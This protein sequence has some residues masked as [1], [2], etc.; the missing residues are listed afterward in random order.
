M[1]YEGSVTQGSPVLQT[2]MLLNSQQGN[3]IHTWIVTSEDGVEWSF[4]SWWSYLQRPFQDQMPVALHTTIHTF[5]LSLP[6]LVEISWGETGNGIVQYSSPDCAPL[7]RAF[8]AHEI[9]SGGL[10]AYIGYLHR[11]HSLH[12]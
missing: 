2:L 12:M 10:D 9:V 7:F 8:S 1:L 6:G 3:E 4:G 11:E 5:P